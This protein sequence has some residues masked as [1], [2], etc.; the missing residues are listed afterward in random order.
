[1]CLFFNHF[2]TTF[3]GISDNSEH[4]LFFH[5]HFFLDFLEDGSQRG[6]QFK[7][8]HNHQYPETDQ[9]QLIGILYNLMYGYM[10]HRMAKKKEGLSKSQ[11]TF[12]PGFYFIR[13]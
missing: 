7:I 11:N 8:M 9:N 5:L 3:L 4:F 13:S 1:M 2:K 12:Y 10:P 6:R